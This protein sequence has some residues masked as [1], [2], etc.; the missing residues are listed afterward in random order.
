MM[1]GLW[2]RPAEE[3]ED[4]L[5][6]SA[7]RV[8]YDEYNQELYTDWLTYFPFFQGYVYTGRVYFTITANVHV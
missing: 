6:H 1:A 8:Q 7:L 3:N 5:A 4:N 2:L